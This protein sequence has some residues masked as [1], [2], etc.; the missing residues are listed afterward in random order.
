MSPVPEGRLF[1]RRVVFLDEAYALTTW[2][3]RADGSG[4]ML[5]AYSAEVVAEL[6]AHLSSYVGRSCLIAAGYEAQMMSDF[7]PA[8]EGLSRR[9]SYVVAMQQYPP[10][11]LVTI[12]MEALATALSTE[13]AVVTS[14]MARNFF[15]LPALTFLEDVLTDARKERA[16]HHPAYPLLHQLF[17]PQAGAMVNLANVAALLIASSQPGLARIGLSV[18]SGSWA[19]GFLDMHDLLVTQLQQ[20]LPAT[21]MGWQA[22]SQELAQIGANN[23]WIRQG[24]WVASDAARERV[25]AHDEARETGDTASET[26]EA[27]SHGRTLRKRAQPSSPAQLSAPASLV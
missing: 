16:D 13:S 12:F 5:D 24:Q 9:F 20:R 25:A 21:P 19:V 10:E 17:A 4:R 11:Y 14:S 27:S 8:N 7:L 1:R 18:S 26:S 2:S 22:A 15:T 23:G 6:V 3:E